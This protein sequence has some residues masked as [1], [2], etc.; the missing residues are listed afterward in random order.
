MVREIKNLDYKRKK[1]MY[2]ELFDDPYESTIDRSTYY[3]QIYE[4]NNLD[5]DYLRNSIQKVLDFDVEEVLKPGKHNKHGARLEDYLVYRLPI[6]EK[7]KKVVIYHELTLQYC[8]ASKGA[9]IKYVIQE[10]VKKKI[11][12]RLSSN[13]VYVLDDKYHINIPLMGAYKPIKLKTSLYLIN[14]IINR[15][16]N[17]VDSNFTIL[18]YIKTLKQYVS[19]Y[20]KMFDFRYY[21][22]LSLKC[23]KLFE[24]ME[25]EI[26]QYH[27]RYLPSLEGMYKDVNSFQKAGKNYIL[28]REWNLF[29]EKKS[30][31]DNILVSLERKLEGSDQLNKYYEL[32]HDINIIIRDNIITKRQAYRGSNL[33]DIKFNISIQN[34]QGRDIEGGLIENY[35]VITETNTP[36]KHEFENEYTFQEPYE[37]SYKYTISQWKT[38]QFVLAFMYEK[39]IQIKKM[40]ISCGCGDL[41]DTV[42]DIYFNDKRDIYRINIP[43]DRS[44]Y[45]NKSSMET[46]IK[47]KIPEKYKVVRYYLYDFWDY[48]EKFDKD[49][50]K[51]VRG[52]LIRD[53]KN[54]TTYYDKPF[55]K[56]LNERIYIKFSREVRSPYLH[57]YFRISLKSFINPS[58]Y[59]FINNNILKDIKGEYVV[60][61]SIA[62]YPDAFLSIVNIIQD[63]FTY[64]D[65]KDYLKNI[66]FNLRYNHIN[67]TEPYKSIDQSHSFVNFMDNYMDEIE[68]VPDL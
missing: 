46:L 34:N 45:I 54:F 68:L 18:D 49:Y 59:P 17:A 36:I 1:M 62:E 10:I 44:F 27:N 29:E 28:Y 11:D 4:Y 13:E 22:F 26:D 19:K 38:K 67:D 51:R 61:M 43:H 23:Q 57:I 2:K 52:A 35:I 7:N 5:V 21:Y 12:K 40:S 47:D 66:K 50:K 41:K 32:D 6:M 31:K 60:N 56:E 3:K 65:N 39:L 25:K 37:K 14:N 63:F 58:D 16:L 30:F 64:R 48:F 9:N 8:T 42:K 55:T 53:N 33:M 20:S 24:V 15:F